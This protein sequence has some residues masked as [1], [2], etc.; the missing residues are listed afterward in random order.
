MGVK[1]LKENIEIGSKEDINNLIEML[2]E[3]GIEGRVF[4]KTVKFTYQGAIDYAKDCIIRLNAR[5]HKLKWYAQGVNLMDDVRD[6]CF[7]LPARLS[8]SESEYADKNKA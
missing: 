1:L 8:K 6:I 2:S 4:K 7:D 5:D 3:F